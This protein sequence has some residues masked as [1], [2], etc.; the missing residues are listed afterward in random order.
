LTNQTNVRIVVGD[1]DRH[2]ALPKIIRGVK[3]KIIHPD[4]SV[5]CENDIALLW[6]DRVQLSN[7]IQFIK[8]ADTI[9][10]THSSFALGWGAIG[11]DLPTSGQLRRVELRLRP[12]NPDYNW[13]I[14]E[15][16]KG[17]SASGICFGDSG[18]PLIQHGKLIGVASFGG[19]NPG[20]GFSHAPAYRDWAIE[21]IRNTPKVLF[22][23]VIKR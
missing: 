5:C 15:P 10:F 7:Q 3:L 20:G 6:F 2:S 11:K 18:G 19:C 14:A 4:Y 13:I 12:I 16:L 17:G 8:L 9:D 23:P 1:H 22:I 21:T